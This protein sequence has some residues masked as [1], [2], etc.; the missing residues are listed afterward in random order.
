MEDFELDLIYE[1]NEYLSQYTDQGE[2]DDESLYEDDDY[3]SQFIDNEEV[4]LSAVRV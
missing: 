4:I 3:L 2:S 1:D